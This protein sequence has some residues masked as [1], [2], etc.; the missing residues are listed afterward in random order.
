MTDHPCTDYACTSAAIKLAGGCPAK[1]LY[2]Y[3]TAPALPPGLSIDSN[4]TIS[5]V[6]TKAGNHTVSLNR[7][8]RWADPYEDAFAEP[9]DE[10]PRASESAWFYGVLAAGICVLALF[11]WAW[12]TYR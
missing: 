11:V 4:D 5:G 7:R 10:P 8:K 2:S 3:S 12:F 1:N 6:P 9:G